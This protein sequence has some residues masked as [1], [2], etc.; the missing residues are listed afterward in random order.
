MPDTGTIARAP[1]SVKQ[2][3]GY[4]RTVIA[5][6]ATA[7]GF[8]AE[9]NFSGFCL[10]ITRRRVSARARRNGKRSESGS[11]LAGRQ[12]HRP[13]V[14]RQEATSSGSRKARHAGARARANRQGFQHRPTN[15]TESHQKPK[16]N[17]QEG[18]PETST[19][20]TRNRTQTRR[21]GSANRTETQAKPPQEPGRTPRTPS[22][23]P[24]Q[25]LRKDPGQ[26]APSPVNTSR[27][28]AY[29]PRSPEEPRA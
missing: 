29:A 19:K 22:E 14:I 28:A 20:A 4:F 25:T 3:L 6:S 12:A 9:K 17:R 15:T 21:K 5:L 10:R 13:P 26:G 1:A 2:I 27:E 18:R 11:N 23:G 24:S 16:P 7:S 8:A